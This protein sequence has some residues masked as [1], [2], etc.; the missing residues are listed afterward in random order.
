MVNPALRLKHFHPHFCL[1]AITPG[2]SMTWCDR[3]H[4]HENLYRRSSD[5]KINLPGVWAGEQ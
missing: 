3:S 4:V 2:S 1:S 5:M